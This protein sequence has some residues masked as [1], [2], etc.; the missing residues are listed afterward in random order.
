MAR[1][2]PE[3]YVANTSFSCLIDGEQYTVRKYDLVAE[4]HPLVVK[5]GENFGKQSD[6]RV[7]FDWEQATAAPG[8]KRNR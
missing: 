7:K 6:Q 5:F 8:E 1:N 2:T 4:G 3:R